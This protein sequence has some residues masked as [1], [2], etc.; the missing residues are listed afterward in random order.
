MFFSLTQ[1]NDVQIIAAFR[2]SQMHNDT[3]E[4][5]KQIDAQFAV[6]FPIIVPRDYWAI[7]NRIAPYKI[8][9][10]FA[11]VALPFVFMPSNH[12]KLY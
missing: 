10:V 8:Q 5:A 4:E 12:G 1:A 11:D 7:K 3:I 9:T 6:G 2:V